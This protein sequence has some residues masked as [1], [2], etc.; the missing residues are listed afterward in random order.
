MPRIATSHSKPG[1]PRRGS[2]G[3]TLATLASL[4]M[5]LFSFAQDGPSQAAPPAAVPSHR[6]ADNVAIITIDE[7]IS[8][9]TAY[10]F[11]R[12]LEVAQE[13]G[14]NAIVIELH[15]PGGEVGAVLEICDAIRGSGITNSVAW[16]HNQAFSGGAIIA[17]ACKEIVTSSSGKMG[18]ALPIRP[19]QVARFMSMSQAERQKFT[20]PLVAE[21][22]ASARLRGWDEYLVQG[23]VALGVELWWVRDAQTGEGFAINEEEFRLLFDGEPP[24]TRPLI[25]SA[26]EAAPPPAPDETP[27]PEGEGAPPARPAGDGAGAYRPAAPALAGLG[28]TA[29]QIGQ[30]STRRRIAAADKGRYELVGYVSSGDGPLVLYGDEMAMLG[31][32]ANLGPTGALDPIQNDADLAAFFG[33]QNVRRLEPTWS[34]S[35]VRIMSHNVARGVLIVIFFVALFLEMS[36]PGIGL[37]GAIAAVAMIALL[38]P[39]ALMGMASWWE[40][41]AIVVGIVLIGLEIFVIPGFGVP[42]VVGLLLLF[43]GLLGTF[44]GDTPGGLFPDSPQATSDLVSG[45]VTIFLS[46]ATAGLLMYFAAKHFGSIPLIGALVLK[47][48]SGEASEEGDLLADIPVR[49]TMLPKIGAVG[50]TVSPLRPSGRAQIADRVID[51]VADLGYIEAGRPV[52]VVS[53][54]TFRVV[55]EEVPPGDG[56]GAA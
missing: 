4:A 3:R 2:L 46:T 44:V 52:R 41:G 29:E 13:A 28:V 37:P 14:A 40:I 10:S 15:T 18:D 16:I 49:D 43:G 5:A 56:T 6:Q 9:V 42:G 7:E 17:L 55:V 25:A 1:C 48:V 54:D 21:V 32:A 50:E 45:L 38:A 19:D 8:A 24:R 26:P 12:R 47:T 53:A 51:V 35:L 36:H 39:P 23:F 11:L 27:P 31:F 30:S 33:A 22:V 20:A 34:E